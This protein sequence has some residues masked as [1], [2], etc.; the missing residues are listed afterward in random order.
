M[1]CW[2]EVAL[3]HGKIGIL[4]KVTPQKQ[5]GDAFLDYIVRHGPAIR[6]ELQEQD[7][8]GG[9][10]SEFDDYVWVIERIKEFAF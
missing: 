9:S 1:P 4:E 8:S 7:H 3:A 5:R 6:R 2:L 10:E